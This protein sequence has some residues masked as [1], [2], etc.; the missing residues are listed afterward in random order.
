MR[1]LQV[2]NKVPYPTKDGGAI[3]CMN[4]TKGFALLGHDVTVLSMNT[5]KHHITID[6]IPERIKNM[7]EFRLV[8]VPA[9]ISAIKLVVNLLFSQ[10]PYNAS[11]FIADN[12]STELIKLLTEKEFD[13]IQLE[14]LYVC[15]YISLIREFSK[16][17]IVY[18]AHNIEHEIWGRSAEINK[19]LK[20]F[21]MRNLSLRIRKFETRLLNNYDVLVP[22]TQRDDSILYGMGNRKPSMVS[23]TGIDSSILFPSSRNL[24]YP[25]LFHIGSMEWGPN[26]EGLLWFIQNCWPVLHKKYP[27]LKFY[28]AGRNAP[29]WFEKKLDQ[30]NVQFLGEVADA[31]EFMNSKAIMIV[32]L[33]SGSG[34]RIKI[35]EGMALG[36]SIVSTPI[37]AEGI[38]VEKDKHILIAENT[39]EFV[40]AVS[41]LVEDKELYDSLGRN[42]IGFIHEKFDNVTTASKLIDFYKQYIK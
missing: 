23:Q 40:E 33:F 28:V 16:A 1:I 21:Y 18:R 9:R 32:P 6:E 38:E 17:L 13:I 10:Q 39:D 34:M 26:Q 42:A 24:E 25:S 37:G 29:A 36:K 27:E 22:I 11:R 30:P 4:L 35:I 7:A 12:F 15:P 8:D 3:A 14:G 19:G 31:Y 20:K 2:T 5:V 41:K